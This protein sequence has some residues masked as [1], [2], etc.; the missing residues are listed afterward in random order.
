MM[1]Y[2][3]RSFPLCTCRIELL[4]VMFH[5]TFSSNFEIFENLREVGRDKRVI[6]SNGDS[7]K[8]NKIGDV[9]I[10]KHIKLRDVLYVHNFRCNLISSRKLS[11]DM[12]CAITYYLNV[13]VI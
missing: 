8:V 2:L 7:L 10:N 1:H 9:I 3:V 11:E 13:C 5:T 6:I 4:I 12:G